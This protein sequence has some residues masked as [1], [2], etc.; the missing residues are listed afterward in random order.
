MK[1]RLSSVANKIAPSLIR[2]LFNMAKSMDDVVDFT[3]GDPDIQPHKNIK[4]AAC[5]AIMNGN[6]RYSQNAGLLSLRE[7]ISQ[8]YL[9]TESLF[10]KPESEIAVTVGAMEGLYLTFLSLINPGD[11]VIIPAPYYVNY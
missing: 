4:E 9:S 6:T 3:L 2:R 1:D 5:N 10:Y 7:V 8:K 11:E